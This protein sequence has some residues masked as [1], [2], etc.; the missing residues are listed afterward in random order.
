M[1]SVSAVNPYV[2]RECNEK[3]FGVIYQVIGG[4]YRKGSLFTF[5][6]NP[7]EFQH[8]TCILWLGGGWD[9]LQ[10]SQRQF[11]F[12]YKRFTGTIEVKD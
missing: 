12:E 1:Q 8:E 2:S 4:D 3:E 10:T 9:R 7:D 5:E 11:K 6:R